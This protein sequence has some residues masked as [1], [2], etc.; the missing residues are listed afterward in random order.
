MVISGGTTPVPVPVPVI[1]TIERSPKVQVK[2]GE[3][4]PSATVPAEIEVLPDTIQR[5]SEA[6]SD[7]GLRRTSSSKIGPL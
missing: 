6:E 3:T 4:A 1:H 7:R 5:T 2:S